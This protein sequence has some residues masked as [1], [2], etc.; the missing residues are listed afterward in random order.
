MSHCTLEIGSVVFHEK[1][2]GHNGLKDRYFIVVLNESPSVQCF[3]VTT[4]PHAET[5]PRLATEFCQIATGECCLPKRCFV[6]FRRVYSFD[7]IQMSSWINSKRVKEI[8]FL[9]DELIARIEESLHRS[10]MLSDAEKEPLL[11]GL[12]SRSAW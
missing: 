8:G 1:F 11:R 12:A 2:D 5:K 10:R 4:Q 9:P 6:D 7:D 3:T